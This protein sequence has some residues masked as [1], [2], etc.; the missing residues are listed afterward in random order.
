MIQLLSKLRQADMG[1]VAEKSGVENLTSMKTFLQ[2]N[3]R[4]AILSETGGGDTAS[5]IT[6]WVFQYPPTGLR[7]QSIST[8]RYNHLVSV[9]SWPTYRQTRMISSVSQFGPYVILLFHL[10]FEL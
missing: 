8:D 4:R 10:K 3:G 5:C 7:G 2:A 1:Y 6:E 9:P